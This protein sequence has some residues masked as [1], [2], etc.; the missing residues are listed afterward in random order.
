MSLWQFAARA[1]GYRKAHEVEKVEAPSDDE[2][3]AMLAR[4]AERRARM[5]N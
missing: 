5:M 3:D 1:H 4:S 2:F